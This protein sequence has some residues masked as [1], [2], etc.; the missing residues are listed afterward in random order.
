M[1]F[2]SASSLGLAVI[3]S[4]CIDVVVCKVAITGVKTGIDAKT[5]ARPAR[6]NIY[7]LYKD[8]KQFALYI[9]AMNT[10]MKT[11]EKTLTSWFSIA[12][13]HGRPYT[14]WDGVDAK[15]GLGGGYCP[16]GNS[17]FPTWHRPYLALIEQIMAGHAQEIA[18]TYKSKDYETAADNL[19]IPYWDWAAT[20]YGIPD[21][22]TWPTIKINTAT[23]AKNVTNPMY[24][25]EFTRSPEPA[26]VFPN[27]PGP[28]ADAEDVFLG[29]QKT[30]VRRPDKSGNSQMVKINSEGFKANN[31]SQ[32]L[33][34]AVYMTFAKTKDYNT[35]ATQNTKGAS[36]EIPHGDVHVTIGGGGSDV[37]T[38]G[39][40]TS[41]AFSAFDPSFW[42]HHANVDRLVAM[43]QAAYPDAWLKEEVNDAPT[44][45]MRPGE[46][47]NE[48]TPLHPFTQADGKTPHTSESSRYIK[49]FGYSYPDI[50]DWKF[51][52]AKD[53]SKAVTQRVNIL[54]N[55]DWRLIS[56]P[57]PTTTPKVKGVTATS[58]PTATPT[59]KSTYKIRGMA[60]NERQAAPKVPREWSVALSAPNNAL[61]EPF[62]VKCTANNVVVGKMVISAVPNQDEIAAGANRTT[63]AEFTLK[64]TLKTTDTGD[65][66]ACIK[67]LQ[68]QLKCEA[69]KTKSDSKVEKKDIKD[70]VIE[71]ADEVVN[72]AKDETEFPTFGERSVHKEI[73]P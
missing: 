49:N 7:D 32:S 61:S 47:L 66:P 25:Y 14:T 27:K 18:K 23:G 51:T 5:G 64:N 70:L 6:R 34:D 53:L 33:R 62:Y 26:D 39:H 35:M 71:V 12:G 50:E 22:M 54:Y 40:M 3:V 19:R 10:L 59:P 2:P 20:P 1:L 17:L 55:K 52:N 56:T 42:I 68:E 13:I 72:L 57:K 37:T 21:M 58:K 44:F 65:V 15:S 8:E 9:Q 41:L 24:R 60:L 38:V 36:F 4:T 73:S 69:F 29:A 11:D 45:T 67:Y 16:H 30:T 31:K 43:W 28:D 46:K 63:H 48:K